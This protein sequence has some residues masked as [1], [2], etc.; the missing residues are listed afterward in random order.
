VDPEVRRL[1]DAVLSVTGDLRLETVLERVTGSACELTGARYGALGVRAE[2]GE[3]AELAEVGFDD[4]AHERIGQLAGGHALLTALIE[5]PRPLRLADL[6]EHPAAAGFAPGDRPTRSFLGVPIQG[7]GAVLGSLYL[8][9]KEGDLPF[10]D[11][12]EGT[13][14]ALAA[15][16]GMAIENAKLFDRAHQRELWLQASH[17]STSALLAGSGAEDVLRMIADRARQVAEAPVA[18]IA[19]PDQYNRDNIVFEVVDGVGMGAEKLTGLSVP[20]S[21]TGSGYVFRTGE[22]MIFRHYG[23]H[24][25]ARNDDPGLEFPSSVE[26]LDSS[27]A[28]PLA[29]GDRIL[30]VLVI[31]RF[32]GERVFTH[33]ELGMAQIFAAQA[34]LAVEFAHAEEDRRRLAVFEDRDR[35][36]RDLHDLVI[37]RLFAIGLGLEGTS[38]LVGR[39]TAERLG[40]FVRQLDRTIQDVRRSIFSLQQPDD[41]QPSLRA[42]L[43]RAVQEAT[44]GLGFEPRMGFD[45]PLDS[46]V[47]DEVRPDLLATVREALS[48]AARH[49]GATAVSVEVKVDPAGACLDLSVTDDGIGMPS[50]PGRR[51]GL[52]NLTR[53]AERWHGTLELT[54]AP[55]GGTTLHWSV[56]MPSRGARMPEPGEEG[57]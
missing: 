3:L 4:R 15:A 2:N 39:Q 44:T 32:R 8:T 38:R 43:V 57:S 26:E 31:A 34:A 13:V 16:A 22:P 6:R 52:A 42:D 30:G 53:R 9:G 10:T 17:D 49:A 12:D 55:G 5:D 18:A 37:Q 46:L 14:L 1:L 48:N 45:G 25:V 27:V 23:G 21:E 11:G 41:G 29:S 24:V 33:A 54:R 28:V 56:R 20:I 47:P 40:G 35:I 7:R 50:E 36:A 51:S 19:L